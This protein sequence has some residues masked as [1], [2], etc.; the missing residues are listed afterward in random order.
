MG[1]PSPLPALTSAKTPRGWG[2]RS[3]GS[4]RQVD[5][6]EPAWDWL[7]EV[8]NPSPFN[9]GKFIFHYIASM[10]VYCQQYL[11]FVL[12]YRGHLAGGGIGN[13]E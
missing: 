13:F 12:L 6:A 1:K 8:P 3:S 5:V 10:I 4:G 2:P 9:S 11:F 7:V